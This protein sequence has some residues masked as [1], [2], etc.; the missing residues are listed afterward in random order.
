MEMH[1]IRYFLAVARELNFTHAAEACHV[2]Q[3]SL[4]QAIRKL[5]EEL[6]GALFRRERNHTHLT[7]LG[8]K[9]V[10]LL[11]RCYE[12]A[13]A[14]RAAARALGGGDAAPLRLALSQTI[15]IGLL[16]PALNELV[17]AMPGLELKFSRGGGADLLQLLKAGSCELAIAG[18]LDAEWDRLDS[19]SLFSEGFQLVLPGQHP[20]AGQNR[21][22]LEDL[23]A[24]RVFARPHCENACDFTDVLSVAGVSAGAAD[25]VGSDRDMLRLVE[26]GLGAGILP[27]SAAIGARLKAIPLEDLQ[28]QRNVRLYAVAGRPRSPAAAA[29]VTLLRAADWSRLQA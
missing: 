15:D 27:N 9:M 1:Q 24:H 22:R 16:L 5:E 21:L 7:D 8:H 25:E 13:L 29:L 10:P 20:L 19:W 14:A 6:G 11:T 18:R 3:P 4:S 23:R 12:S 17:R 28:I 2:S 26:A